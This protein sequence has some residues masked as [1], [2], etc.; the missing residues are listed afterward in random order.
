LG[1]LSPTRRTLVM[2]GLL[3]SF[4]YNIFLSLTSVT[5]LPIMAR[6]LNGTELYT[7]GMVLC[8]V[9]NTVSIPIGG[10]LSRRFPA[11]TLLLA[12]NALAI[13]GCLAT[14]FAHSMATAMI[15]FLVGA[16]F[17]FGANYTLTPIAINQMFEKRP[18]AFWLSVQ[19]TIYSGSMLAA[20]MLVG[21]ISDLWS[22]RLIMVIFL[23]LAAAGTALLFL[24]PSKRPPQD[25]KPMDISGI[26]FMMAGF[27]SFSFAS[28]LGGSRGW[29]DS[30]TLSLLGLSFIMVW[31]FLR[32]E[33]RKGDDAMFPLS[34]FRI[35]VMIPLFIAIS[36]ARG[37]V[38]V[39]RTY[40]PMYV[41]ES[42]GGTATQSGITMACA[43]VMGVL[44]N[45]PIG[46]YMIRT[47]NA[48][49]ALGSGTATLVFVL[50]YF[51]FLI[52][53]QSS[54]W[55]V[56]LGMLVFSFSSMMA[57][58]ASIVAAQLVL[59][60][61]SVVQGVMTVQFGQA[62]V[63]TCFSAINGA[64]LNAFSDLQ[65]GMHTC[66]LLSLGFCALVAV[67]LA[68]LRRRMKEEGKICSRA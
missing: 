46:R 3:L 32:E 65:K 22:W 4:F 67:V 25:G 63:S 43:G 11:K 61:E 6:D 17:S 27:L 44:L 39:L 38:T 14:Y 16:S 7:L 59:P 42:M 45:V 8:F 55:L 48:V 28:N 10:M 60:A 1:Q 2:G 33:K 29:G 54:I 30:L 15:S 57:S 9:F 26:L 35:P 62:I 5:L 52:T 66:Y 47:G 19:G 56:W 50:M 20:P 51:L 68:R 37:A 21:V 13:A 58:T 64:L 36:L 53:P 40:M 18:A 23:P 34:P 49:K 24:V 12:C 31:L 41:L